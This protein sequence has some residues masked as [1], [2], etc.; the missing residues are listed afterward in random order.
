MCSRVTSTDILILQK[1]QRNIR[2][3]EGLFGVPYFDP[4]IDIGVDVLKSLA[5]IYYYYYYLDLTKNSSTQA[6]KSW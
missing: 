6:T 3:F 1:G 5:Y 2:I 4:L